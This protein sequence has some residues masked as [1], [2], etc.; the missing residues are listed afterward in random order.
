MTRI[1]L[2]RPS[3]LAQEG[4]AVLGPPTSLTGLTYE[5]FGPSPNPSP[6]PNNNIIFIYNIYYIYNII[7]PAQAQSG[8][9]GPAPIGAGP[10]RFGPS[11]K[12]EISMCP[13]PV[14]G[15]IPHGSL[16]W[17]QSLTETARISTL[18][19]PKLVGS[20]GPTLSW[21]A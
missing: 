9:W 7:I 10:S 3:Y 12:V 4:H 18:P 20:G 11:P 17:A 16:C 15:P 14:L 6:S 5:G 13:I 1:A 8:D 19:R 2:D 21:W